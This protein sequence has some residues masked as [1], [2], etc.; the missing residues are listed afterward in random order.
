MVL[1]EHDSHSCDQISMSF[2]SLLAREEPA[3][4][5]VTLKSKADDD[6]MTRCNG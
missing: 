6:P 3:S 5:K 1:S 2:L 4:R